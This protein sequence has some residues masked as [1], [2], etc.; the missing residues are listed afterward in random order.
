MA[1]IDRQRRLV[2]VGRI[3]MGEKRTSKNGKKYPASLTTWRLTSRDR[4]R[5]EAVAAVYGGT[6]KPWEGEHEVVTTTDVLDIAVMPGQA[7]S[8]WNEQW[9]QQPDRGDDKP[10]PVMCL[11]RC[12]GQT[13][14]ISD[15]PCLCRAETDEGAERA[16]KSTTHLSVILRKIPGFGVWRVTSRGENAA[17]ELAGMAE[18]LEA[19]TARG[20]PVPARLRLDQRESVGTDGVSHRFVVPV[21]DLDIALDNLLSAGASGMYAL[22]APA[23]VAIASMSTTAIEAPPFT[24][25]PVDDLPPGPQRSVRDQVVGVTSPPEKPRRSNA[26]APIPSTGLTPRGPDPAAAGSGGADGTESATE[27]RSGEAPDPSAPPVSSGGELVNEQGASVVAMRCADAGIDDGTRA[28][29]LWAFSGGRYTSAK[30]V[31]VA[32]LEELYGTLTKI[33][34]GALVLDVDENGERGPALL[35]PGDSAESVGAESIEVPPH[36]WWKAKLARYSGVGVAK[37]IRQARTV[38]PELGLDA[39]EIKGLD[40]LTDPAL[41]E[42]LCEWLDGHAEAVA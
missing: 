41:N 13:E 16:C 7:L 18:M 9:G 31:P 14:L 21:I 36:V 34:T 40:H 38:A 19:L 1:I 39:N 25:V 42:R 32:E 6:V 17:D 30:E 8:Q 15:R 3:R 23:P 35:L 33:R 12:D 11:R 22:G 28:A 27:Q 37:L 24:K 5:V 29:F 4:Q 10:R 26:A 2:E 20:T